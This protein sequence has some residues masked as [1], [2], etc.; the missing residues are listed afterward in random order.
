MRLVGCFAHCR[1][2]FFEA[3]ICRYPVGLQDL[4]RIRAIYA[5]DHAVRHAPP[6]QRQAL[7]DQHVHPLMEGFFDWVHAARA[8]TPGRNLATKAL[9]YAT[10]R[11][12]CGA[13]STTSTC[14]SI[15]RAPKEPCEKSSS[16]A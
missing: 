1:R 5:A 8:I 14:R 4:L 16:V 11:P 13:P 10:K 12:S 6:A 7:R 15:T 2:Y 9:G 3:A